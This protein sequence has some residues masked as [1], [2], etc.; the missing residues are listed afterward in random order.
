[1]QHCGYAGER[2]QIYGRRPSRLQRRL[3]LLLGVTRLF[4]PA[5]I[6]G[7][8]FLVGQAL[9]LTRHVEDRL[10]GFSRRNLVCKTK[11]LS[12]KLSILFRSFCSHAF[13]HKNELTQEPSVGC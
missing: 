4:L 2:G 6:G 11:T 1:M 7:A 9:P 13:V 5:Q 3:R 12:R 8:L 10:P